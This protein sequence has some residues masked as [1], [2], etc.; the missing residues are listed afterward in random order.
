MITRQT[1]LF[2]FVDKKPFA[3]LDE[4][5]LFELKKLM[6]PELNRVTPEE[7][8]DN[9]AKWMLKNSAEIVDCLTTSPRSRARKVNGGTRKKSNVAA[10]ASSAAE[11]DKE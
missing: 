3:N 2:Y 10:P 8:D 9:L 1:Q 5:K 4:A 11:G 6:P 7:F